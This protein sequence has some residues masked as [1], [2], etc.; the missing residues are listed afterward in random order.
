MESETEPEG[1]VDT[2]PDSDPSSDDP[3]ADEPSNDSDESPDDN[4]GGQGGG[5]DQPFV[6]SEKW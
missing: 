3:S 2:N 6:Y 4:T 1:G 5:S